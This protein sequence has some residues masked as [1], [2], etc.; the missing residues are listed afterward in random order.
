MLAAL[1]FASGL[2]FFYLKYVPL[3]KSFQIL[4]LP[5]IFIVFVSTVISVQGGTLLFVFFFPLIN[6]LP[7]FFSIFENIPH[8]PTSLVLFLFYFLGWLVHKS[9]FPSHLSFKLPIF[10]P[11]ILFSLMILGSGIITFLRYGNF[12]PFLADSVYELATNVHGVTAGGAM[13]SVLFF[14]L[15]Y[16]TGFAFFFILLSTIDSKK[17]IKR[18]LIVLL[19]STSICLLVG[20]YQHFK[21]PSF[22]NTPLRINESLINSTFKDPLSFGAYL[23]I[24]IPVILAMTLA[25]KGTI[26]I[27]SFLLFF[28]ALFILPQT[29]S[30]SGLIAALLSLFLFLA[31]ALIKLAA[32]KRWKSHSSRKRI[33][34]VSISLL[35]IALACFIFLLS[36]ESEAYKRLTQLKHPYGGLEDTFHIRWDNQWRMGVHMLKDYPFSGVGVGAYIIELPNYAQ[37]HPSPYEKWTDSAENYFLQVGSELGIIAIVFVLW[38]FWEIFIQVKRSMG[39]YFLSHRWK[40]IQIGIS[41]A[42]FSLFIHFLVHTYIGSYEIKYTFWLLVSLLFG[43]PKIEKEAEKK[44]YFSKESKI[45]AVLVL[46]LFCGL[47]LW[48]STHSLSLKNRTEKFAIPQNFGF[49]KKERTEDGR[50]FRWT[51]SYGGLTIKIE[52]P[53]MEIPMLA[54]HPDIRNNPVKVR[55]YLI[56]ELFKKKKL[57]D[58]IILK[59]SVWETYQYSIPEEMDHQ[60]ILLF[61]VSRTWNPLKTY[62]V[63]DPRNLGIAIG[64]IQFKDKD[65]HLENKRS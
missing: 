34:L 17:S 38:I 61:K 4:L 20:F 31:F 24:L 22:G 47:H 28:L 7:Y 14:S 39:P 13:M 21:D 16:L 35:S 10:K 59:Q 2:Y 40:T 50:E 33:A 32:W 57:L 26:R 42:V 12:Y 53:V 49:Y 9:L 6:S 44:T 41:C 23:S 37:M 63:P 45:M 27:S 65:N 52:K 36:K 51:R 43:L 55:I 58:E 25:F 18:I 15:N 60:V 5:L 3:V 29:G 48:N 54:T 8:A 1:S 56:Q 30:K 11:M 46:T 19:M 62:R 64:T